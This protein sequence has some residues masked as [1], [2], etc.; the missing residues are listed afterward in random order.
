LPLQL[1]VNQRAS[2]G[3][4]LLVECCRAKHVHERVIVQC[5]RE[6]VEMHG[7]DPSLTAGDGGLTPLCIGAARGLPSLVQFLL[8]CGANAMAAG[9]GRFRQWGSAASIH[10]TFRPLDWAREMLAAE[11]AC[12]VS[13]LN[14]RPLEKCVAL[15]L[16]RTPD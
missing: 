7:A 15:L 13:A 10:G 1:R 9:T 5:A 16:E 14:L 8:G 4:T 2:I 11:R 12:R 6:L 3:G